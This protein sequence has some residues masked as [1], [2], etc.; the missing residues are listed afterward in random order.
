MRRMAEGN[1]PITNQPAE[2]DSVINDANVVRCLYYV[3]L[4]SQIN[5]PVDNEEIKKIP[6]NCYNSITFRGKAWTVYS[7]HAILY[8][9]AYEM[10]KLHVLTD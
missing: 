2:G 7:V 8:F 6:W 5:E 3:T 9:R 1:N 10:R 4:A